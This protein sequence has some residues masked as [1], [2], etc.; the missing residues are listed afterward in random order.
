MFLL[1][2]RAGSSADTD[3]QSSLR[4]VILIKE[5]RQR[6]K[7]T[8][9]EIN[10]AVA[11]LIAKRFQYSSI[12][13]AMQGRIGGAKGLLTISFDDPEETPRIWI[14][15]SQ[16]EIVHADLNHRSRRIFDLVEVSQPSTTPCFLSQQ[17]V[18]IFHSTGSQLM[19][20]RSW[21]RESSMMRSVLLWTRQVL[22][23]MK[24]LDEIERNGRVTAKRL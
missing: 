21:W 20:S 11:K 22:I 10:I 24:L 17:S 2:Y 7:S 14:R 3:L 19:F 13:T 18:L 23:Q 9:T 12:P 15:P 5:S 6:R 16:L 4:T 8:P 1:P